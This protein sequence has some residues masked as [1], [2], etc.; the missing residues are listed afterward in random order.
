MEGALAITFIF[1]GGALFL[2]ALSPVGRALAARIRGG[3]PAS[4]ES[5]H[6]MEALERWMT[7]EFE[8]LH[9]ELVEVQERVD[10]TERLL[11]QQR[12]AGE[13]AEGPPE[14]P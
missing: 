5:Q 11:A 7:E 4:D 13:L 14:A 1:G 3:T 6:R 8:A 10:F 9:Q 2:L 12:N